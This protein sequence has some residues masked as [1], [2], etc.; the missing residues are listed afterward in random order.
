[1]GTLDV[2][3]LRSKDERAAVLKKLI[4]KDWIYGALHAERGVCWR[5]R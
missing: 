5:S 1:M 4:L 2:E 3:L